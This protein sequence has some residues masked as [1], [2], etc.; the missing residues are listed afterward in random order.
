MP[1]FIYPP[2]DYQDRD[3]IGGFLNFYAQPFHLTSDDR[4]QFTVGRD[5]DIEIH[6]ITLPYVNSVSTD[7]ATWDT[8]DNSLFWGFTDADSG[9]ADWMID[10]G[11]DFGEFFSGA[12][13]RNEIN[14]EV[15]NAGFKGPVLRQR[16]YTWNLINRSGGDHE[17]RKI[18]G[19]CRAFQA[20]VYPM[21]SPDRTAD[22]IA[23]PPPMWTVNY[24]PSA[25][26]G[27]LY[28]DKYGETT[29]R[30]VPQ[31]SGGVIRTARHPSGQRRGH[32][33]FSSSSGGRIASGAPWIKGG[34]Q[35]PSEKFAGHNAWRW[36]MDMFPSAL[37]NVSITP[38]AATDSVQ[39]KTSSGWPLVTVLNL[40]FLEIDQAIAGGLWNYIIPYSWA[41]DE[42]NNFFAGIRSP[43]STPL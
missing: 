37:I 38:T 29:G 33:G 30:L 1:S 34:P 15:S 18:A 17:G 23:R 4:A 6:N 9:F 14:M 24:F 12:G 22:N 26:P 32:P 39:T 43:G 21:M 8:G 2:A 16:H 3:E 27:A 28:V 40:S 42:D 5:S 10:L 31:R 35:H 13:W 36:N 41:Q 19:L 25:N 7:T 20:S 11:H